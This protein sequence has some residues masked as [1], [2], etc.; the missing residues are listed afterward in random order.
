M[1]TCL[2]SSLGIHEG[3]VPGFPVDT[4]SMDAQISYVEWQSIHI[5]PLHILLLYILI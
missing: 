3:F 2:Q 4:E 1:C 5:Q